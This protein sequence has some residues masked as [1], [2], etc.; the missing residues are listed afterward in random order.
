LPSTVISSPINGV[1]EQTEQG[2]NS[3]IKARFA[4]GR[5]PPARVVVPGK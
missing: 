1:R 5:R 3:S 4:A 2:T